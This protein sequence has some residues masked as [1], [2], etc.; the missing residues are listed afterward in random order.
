MHIYNV[1]IQY[2]LAAVGSLVCF[3]MIMI[4]GREQ[5]KEKKLY[6]ATV[7]FI[8]NIAAIGLLSSYFYTQ[9][10]IFQSYDVSTL[11]RGL[12]YFLYAVLLFSWINML[13]LLCSETKEQI[14]LVSFHIGKIFSL[15]GIIVFIILAMFCMDKFY[16]IDNPAM[17]NI[18][19][20]TENIFAIIASFIIIICALKNIPFILLSS[21]RT[22]AAANSAVLISY[23][24]TQIWFTSGI[25]TVRILSWG[26]EP[27]DCSGWI[28]FI[29]DVLTC[30]FVYK[31]DFQQLYTHTEQESTD[32]TT[33]IINNVAESHKLTHRE[34]EI[35]ELV[36]IGFSN[37]EIASELF[38]SL[39]TV[40]THMRNIFE[41]TGVSSRMELTYIINQQLCNTKK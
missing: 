26:D 17:Q 35:L 7:L 2:I 11:T 8:S 3:I 29:M 25:G 23:F 40:K 19:H 39:N 4:Q 12:D 27:L 20:A 34:R 41:K 13:Q 16:Y 38:I 15:I 14:S 22:Y 32:I 31:K 10:V 24:L 5:L 1:L 28:L 30:C 6:R 21:T 33:H 9:E 36:Y 18:Y 37:A